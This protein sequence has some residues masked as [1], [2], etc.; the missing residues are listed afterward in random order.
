MHSPAHAH[1][2]ISAMHSL[3]CSMLSKL[4]GPS[5]A[6]VS[7]RRA[8]SC[9]FSRVSMRRALAKP[10]AG[11]LFQ[12]FGNMA[13]AGHAGAS[14]GASPRGADEVEFA[15]VFG[16]GETKGDEGPG[17]GKIASQVATGEVVVSESEDEQGPDSE[18]DAV[19]VFSPCPPEQESATPAGKGIQRKLGQSREAKAKV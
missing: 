4:C 12:F 2:S 17:A 15:G 19:S 9:S 14:V 3:T 18:S 6:I 8:R 1:A 7:A 13:P 16:A 11:T 10:Q 5:A